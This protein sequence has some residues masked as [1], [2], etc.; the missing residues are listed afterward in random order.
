MKTFLVAAAAAMLFLRASA[1]V[2][3]ELVTDQDQFLPSESLPMA[4]KITN[5]S[6]QRL[7]LG[8]EANWLTFNV[9]SLEGG[10]VIKKAEVPVA[11]EFDLESSQMATKRVDL[12]PYFVLNRQGRYKVTATLRIKDWSAQMTSA[13]KNFDVISGAYLWS[14]EF[15]VPEATNASPEVRK[16]TLEQ[17]NY[18]RSQLRLYLQVSD[19]AES[20]IYKVTPLG[21]MVSF[22]QTEAQVDRASQLHVLWQAGAQM[23]IYCLV[24]PNGTVLKR[25]NYDC[26]TSRPRLTVSE[27]GFVSVV[28]GTRRLQPV[29]LPVVRPPN[30]LPPPAK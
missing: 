14:Q 6:G 17:A 24:S 27:S 21:P 15:G 30:E 8:A 7:H 16:Y 29:E 9:E 5:R 13:P 4:V 28:G 1:Q 22:S 25:D 20:R 18:L 10:V 2:D 3:L 19:A 23:F 12:Q 11:G 26:F